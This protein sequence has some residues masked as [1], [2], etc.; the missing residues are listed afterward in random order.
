[1]IHY[2][3]QDNQYS[4]HMAFPT[5]CKAFCLGNILSKYFHLNI[6]GY[7]F[8]SNVMNT[9]YHSKL[10]IF[11]IF[12]YVIDL[13]IFVK[14]ILKALVCSIEIKSNLQCDIY[15]NFKKKCYAFNLLKVVSDI[16]IK[17][18]LYF[19]IFNTKRVNGMEKCL[20][21]IQNYKYV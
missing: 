5:C 7:C 10:C 15:F 13:Q 3:R 8:R 18:Y 14:S 17:I 12:I 20:V 1:M 19:T 6:L 4:S 21:S 9:E 2:P 11:E 16:S